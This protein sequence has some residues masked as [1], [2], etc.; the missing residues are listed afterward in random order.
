MVLLL[1][2]VYDVLIHY[3]LVKDLKSLIRLFGRR[4]T[5]S[6][7]PRHRQQQNSQQQQLSL[8]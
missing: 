2:S 3:D 1:L 8:R 6:F 4:R 7:L 5:P